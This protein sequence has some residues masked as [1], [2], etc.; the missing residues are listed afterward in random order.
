MLSYDASGHRV[1]V[2]DGWGETHTFPLDKIWIA[3]RK[4]SARA[5]NR[6]YAKLIGAG[7][8]AGGIIGSILTALVLG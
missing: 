7:A 5:R 8:V 2:S 4:D 1:T 3:P 6:V